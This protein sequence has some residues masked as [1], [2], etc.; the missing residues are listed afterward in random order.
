MCIDPFDES[1]HPDGALM[2]IFTGEVAH[3]DVTAD[4]ALSIG[5]REMVKFKNGWPERF[6]NKLSKC[7]VTMDAKK[8]H[9]LVAQEKV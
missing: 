2:N 8:K 3:P 4:E 9:I 5:Q 6:Y 1:S 7:V